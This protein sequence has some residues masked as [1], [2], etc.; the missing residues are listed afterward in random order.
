M[1]N[2]EDQEQIDPAVN[3]IFI[4]DLQ[5]S[6]NCRIARFGMK[7]SKDDMLG[8]L[9]ESTTIFVQSS[10]VFAQSL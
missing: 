4:F 6:N 5:M 7:R 8:I 1:K 2:V 10:R 3:T 9:T